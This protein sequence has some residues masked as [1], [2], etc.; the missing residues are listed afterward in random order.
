MTVIISAIWH[1]WLLLI[2]FLLY[3]NALT[4]PTSYQFCLCCTSLLF[5]FFILVSA[6]QWQLEENIKNLIDLAFFLIYI[7]WQNITKYNRSDDLWG[8]LLI[9][10]YA[11]LWSCRKR[12]RWALLKETSG[13]TW[14]QW[15]VPSRQL[16]VQS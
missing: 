13:M 7:P 11:W 3:F 9:F 16:L 4:I 10:H 14:I 1:C 6:Y 5:H 15:W 8:N 12:F 2:A